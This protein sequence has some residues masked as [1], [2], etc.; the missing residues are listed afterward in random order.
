MA[1]AAAPSPAATG[2]DNSFVRVFGA[3][4]SPKPTFESIA[5][6]PTWIVPLI[7]VIVVSTLVI[8]VF[9]QRVGWRN[10]MIR[11]NQQ[12]SRVQK[13]MEQMT[14]DQREHLLD[15][16]TKIA[17]IFGYVGVIL[18]TIVGALL[19]G[20]VL[21]VALNL[22][23]GSKIPFKTSLGIVSYSWV[24]AIIAG[25]LGILIMFI[26][27]PSTVDIEHLVASNA[28]AFLSDDSPKWLLT[29]LTSFD[30]FVFWTMIL[31]ALG[32]SATDP[33]K[34]SFGKALTTIFIVWILYIVVKVGL[35]AAFA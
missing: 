13:Q 30:I 4:F 10:F 28:G 7:L 9:G 27:D 17:P 16:Q 26:K 19:V 33:K 18:G 21:M 6:R 3:I 22:A 32:Y 29:L 34:L 2:S 1:S 24:P 5:R 23:S 8:A 35:T 11:Q 15:Q 20:A 14:P 12:S 31:M 25:L